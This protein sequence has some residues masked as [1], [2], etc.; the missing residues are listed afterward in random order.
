M[1]NGRKVFDSAIRGWFTLFLN[2]SSK[3]LGTEMK[4]CGNCSEPGLSGKGK[5][6]ECDTDMCNH[7][8]LW[9]WTLNL[10][11]FSVPRCFNNIEDFVECEGR[12]KCV[13]HYD[14]G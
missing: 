4:R 10:I 2:L 12:D 6:E 9:I 1:R 13:I 11:C 7:S 14:K 3:Y 8:D 5:C